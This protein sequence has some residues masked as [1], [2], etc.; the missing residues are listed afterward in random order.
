MEMASYRELAAFAQLSSD[1]DKVTQAQLNRGQRLQEILKQ[2]QY[3]PYSLANQVISLF[4]ATNGFADVIPTEKIRNWEAALLRFMDTSYPEIGQ[5]I[6][7]RK[8]ITAD[9]EAKMR[10]AI[11]TFNS[12]W[13][14]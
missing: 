9:N 3:M 5:D 6:L 14:A 4:A 10:Q 11:Q 2:P 12:S 13:Q 8:Q 1:L 7:E